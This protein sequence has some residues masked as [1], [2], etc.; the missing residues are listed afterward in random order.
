MNQK[1]AQNMKHKAVSYG[2]LLDHKNWMASKFGC[3]MSGCFARADKHNN[4]SVTLN[5]KVT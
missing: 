4:I 5:L 3:N 2:R 1:V